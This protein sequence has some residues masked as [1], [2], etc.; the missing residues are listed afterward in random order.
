MPFIVNRHDGLGWDTFPHE[1]GGGYEAKS[2]FNFKGPCCALERRRWRDLPFKAIFE[3]SSA[4]IPVDSYA[5]AVNEQKAFLG[6]WR[7]LQCELTSLQEA[8]SFDDEVLNSHA[9]SWHP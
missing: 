6:W 7:Y 9:R 5:S 1:F 8:D 4:C 3:A 2:E